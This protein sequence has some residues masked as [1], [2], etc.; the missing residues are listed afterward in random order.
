LHGVCPE[1]VAADIV[2]RRQD[3]EAVKESFKS[4]ATFKNELDKLG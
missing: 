1:H 3:M 4:L 2:T